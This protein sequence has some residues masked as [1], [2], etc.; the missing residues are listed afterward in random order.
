MLTPA[1]LTQGEGYPQDVR[2]VLLSH[3]KACGYAID[4][5][6]H[7]KEEETRPNMRPRDWKNWKVLESRAGKSVGDSV[8]ESWEVCYW[9]KD[10]AIAFDGQKGPI[11]C[12]RPS[13]ESRRTTVTT[14]DTQTRTDARTQITQ[15]QTD[16]S[17]YTQTYNADRGPDCP[18]ADPDKSKVK[19]AQASAIGDEPKVK[20]KKR[21]TPCPTQGGAGGAQE[22]GP[23]G[24][25]E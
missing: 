17:T 8:G 6:G 1:M 9:V 15:I 23:Q 22:I 7:A 21:D 4:R 19:T 11:A 20:T 13:G 18:H 3:A 16:A 5:R 10:R 24:C 12:G 25:C 2:M 14:V